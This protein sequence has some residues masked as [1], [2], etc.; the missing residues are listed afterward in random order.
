MDIKAGFGTCGVRRAAWRLAAAGAALLALAACGFQPRGV[1][2]LPF[3]SVYVAG[4]ERSV[5]V[6]ELRRAIAAGSTTKV[7]D[8]RP[9]AQA[10][11]QVTG[12]TREKRILS[13]GG[14]GKVREFELQYRVGI[15]V[16]DRATNKMIMPPT[17]VKL[18]RDF[19]FSDT[20]V[21]AKES[22]E[23]GLYDDMQA[24]AVQQILRRLSAVKL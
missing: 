18:R 12:E 6:A 23:A 20:Q 4:G 1:V 16:R 9:D 8:Q 17:E 3:E 21:L 5:L 13:L 2:T 19:T 11:I 22:E 24:D 14:D 10:E 7:V 15:R